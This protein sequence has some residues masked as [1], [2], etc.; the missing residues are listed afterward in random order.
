MRKL[1][2]YHFLYVQVLTSLFICLDSV[3]IEGE[4]VCLERHGEQRDTTRG[5]M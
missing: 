1:L 5:G 3:S 4:G 2:V